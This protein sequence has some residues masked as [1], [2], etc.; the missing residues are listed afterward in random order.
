MRPITLFQAVGAWMVGRLLVIQASSPSSISI[1]KELAA[2]AAVYLSYGVGMVANDSADAALDAAAKNDTPSQSRGDNN[3]IVPISSTSKTKKSQRA[4]ASG[5]ITVKQGWIFTGILSVLAM[6]VAQFGVRAASP[7]FSLWCASNLVF[8]LLYAAGLQN[9]FLI[10]NLLV[11][12]L[13]ISPLWGAKTL[14]TTTSTI[15]NHKMTLLAVAGFALGVVRE[16]LKDIQ[17][18]E[19]DKGTKST[20]PIVLGIP[21]TQRISMLAL[22]GTLAVLQT[23]LYRRSF[24]ASPLLY[25]VTWGS[26]T[27]MCL[28]AALSGNNEI[29]KQQSMVKKSI[30]VLLLGLIANMMMMTGK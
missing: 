28:W 25:S 1:G 2:M 27:V 20:L 13:F 15:Q 12:W 5:R 11:G 21:L 3:H 8:M 10:K 14:A 23:P 18:V 6:T 9:L 24:C 30:Y 16:V 26:A 29:D 19:L 7:Q 4:I 22:G 17:D